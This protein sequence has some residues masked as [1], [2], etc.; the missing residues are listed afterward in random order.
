MGYVRKTHGDSINSSFMKSVSEDG[1]KDDL[2]SDAPFVI[3]PPDAVTGR[4]VSQQCKY[5]YILPAEYISSSDEPIVRPA[6]SKMLS[7]PM[8]LCSVGLFASIC[9]SCMTNVQGCPAQA[10]NG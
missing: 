6:A 8:T 7:R 4:N 1:S 3:Y 5:L 10:T 2:L 9:I